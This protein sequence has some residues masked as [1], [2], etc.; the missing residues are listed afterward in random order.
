MYFP[1]LSATTSNLELTMQWR[2]HSPTLPHDDAHSSVQYRRQTCLACMAS[3][4]IC[5]GCIASARWHAASTTPST[6]P[7]IL[8]SM[9]L[10]AGSGGR[11][12][13]APTHTG[14]ATLTPV[15]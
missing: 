15:C 11:S 10:S 4:G 14:L 3:G 9:L 2:E 7:P 12:G 1:T 6:P 8:P 13:G 5:T